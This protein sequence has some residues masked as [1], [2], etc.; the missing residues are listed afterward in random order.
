MAYRKKRFPIRKRDGVVE[1]V[2]GYVFDACFSDG[3]LFPVGVF[4]SATK[5]NLWTVSDLNTGMAINYG[6]TRVDAVKKFQQTYCSK[7]ERT[8]YNNDHSNAT[9]EN[10][11]ETKTREFAELLGSAK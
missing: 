2:N 11:Y 5:H 6:S 9:H 7:L 3:M 4:K 1:H 8:V 10:W